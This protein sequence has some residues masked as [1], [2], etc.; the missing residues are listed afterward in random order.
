M[1]GSP[2]DFS[3]LYRDFGV[4]EV[5]DFTIGS[6]AAALAAVYNGIPYQGFCHND[7]HKRWGEMHLE[8]MFVAVIG[9]KKIKADADVVAKVEKYLHRSVAEAKWMLPEHVPTQAEIGDCFSG[10]NDSDNEV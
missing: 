2:S 1:N 5:K 8:Q 10:G 9:L 6:G 3:T 7:A 4:T